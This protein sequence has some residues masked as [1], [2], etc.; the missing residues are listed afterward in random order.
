SIS[1]YYNKASFGQLSITPAEETQGVTNDGVIEVTL[2]GNHPNNTDLSQT[3]A[4][5][6]LT[7]ANPYINFASY[8]KDGDEAVTSSELHIIFIIAGYEES[9]C[10]SSCPGPK[11]WG[12]RWWLNSPMTLDGVKVGTDSSDGDYGGYAM[13]GEIHGT[14]GATNHIAQIGI[15]VH[16]LGHD[17]SW[18]DLYDTDGSSQGV[19]RWSI[20]GSGSWN[21]ITYDGDTPALPDAYLKWYQGWIQPIHPG[22]GATYLLNQASDSKDV[23]AMGVVKAA[24]TWE[25]MSHSG[26][27][28]FFLVENRQLSGYDAGLPS[29]GILIWHI[30]ET[31]T[32][33][34]SAN[35]NESRPLV[36]LEQADGLHDLYYGYDRGDAGD[37]YPGSTHK[38]NFGYATNPN[39]R[40]YSGSDS[41]RSLVINSTACSGWMNVTY[42]GPEIAPPQPVRIYLPGIL[43]Q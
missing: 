43:A 12:H 38:Y 34:N 39:S 17:L 5:A 11:I 36:E 42:S 4:T 32:Y 7:A 20:M 9:F 26:S 18:P 35:A 31:R 1:D 40:Y 33:T 24:A 41:T 25:F 15:M 30:D 28:E 13:F 14:G 22:N 21:G 19:G 3:I 29:C 23:L 10:G 37:P 27:G 6:A 16:E 8:N 2:G